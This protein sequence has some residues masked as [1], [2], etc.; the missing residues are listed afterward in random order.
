MT[1]PLRAE[2]KAWA[3]RGTLAFCSA[4]V[5][6]GF[7]TVKAGDAIPGITGNGSEVQLVL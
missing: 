6:M 1:L 5:A 7:A 3:P 4:V 2:Y